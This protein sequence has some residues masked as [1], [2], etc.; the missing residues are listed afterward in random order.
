MPET[1]KRII[2]LL[3]DS[4]IFLDVPEQVLQ[5]LAEQ[6]QLQHLNAGDYL[7]REGE[8]GD[9]LYILTYGRLIVMREDN[10]EEPI[11]EIGVGDVVGELALLVDT[12]RTA[13]VRAVR[14][15]T[16]IK[17]SRPLF[18]KI[19]QQHPKAAMKVVSACVHRLL[20]VHSDKKHHIKTLAVIPCQ[21][22]VNT[23]LITTQLKIAL[24]KYAK[25]CVLDGSLT[26]VQDMLK[27]P[28]AEI[29]DVL[30]E[31][32]KSNDI[33]LYVADHERSQWTQWCV[34]HADKILLLAQADSF[35]V[36]DVEAYVQAQENIIAEKVLLVLHKNTRRLPSGTKKLIEINPCKQHFHVCDVKDFERVARFLLGRAISVVM[37]GGG[38]R[39][40]AHYGLVRAFQERG[41]PID[42]VGGTSFGAL[43][44][45][46]TAKGM[47]H[48][49]MNAMWQKFVKKIRKVI[50]L[51][52]PV[53]AISSGKVLYELLTQPFPEDTDIEDLWLP[54]FT[55]ASN[56]SNF[57]MQAI[58]SGPAWLAIRA[59]L[60]I[61]G[62]FPPVINEGEAL[63]DGAAF[64]NLPVDIMQ[65]LNNDGIT[66]ASVATSLPPKETFIGFDRGIS[67]WRIL[68]DSM[69]DEHQFNMPNIAETLMNASLATSNRHQLQ[70]EYLADYLLRLDVGEFKLLDIDHWQQIRDKGYA[71]ACRILDENGITA[72]FLGV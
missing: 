61:P 22:A 29:E 54:S 43:I 63:V 20:P 23:L 59:S 49:Q 38:L 31:I 15:C 17:I 44:A 19:I 13:S 46:A 56:I 8:C 25:V 3:K 32:E 26:Q 10:G 18:E 16:L 14:D 30:S 2:S 64:N 4:T 62:V 21:Q 65:S 34:Q 24:Q 36:S 51:T 33:T 68:L 7:M 71:S 53:S 27:K 52:L 5:S 35:A 41:I 12:P 48:D 60:S 66:I 1:K 11:G 28:K 47:S 67:G 37:S 9:C 50:D 58:R 55:V 72:D 42:M 57:N 40:V 6:M 45:L 39:G 70:M 69:R